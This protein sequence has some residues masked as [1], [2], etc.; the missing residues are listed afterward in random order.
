MDGHPIWD[1]VIHEVGDNKDKSLI[2]L[3][4]ALF[5]NPHHIS[6]ERMSECLKGKLKSV[7]I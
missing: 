1:V 3:G 5:I 6:Y 7:D 4:S 2:R